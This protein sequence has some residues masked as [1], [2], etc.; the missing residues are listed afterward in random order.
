MRDPDPLSP[1]MRVLH[2]VATATRRGGEMFAADLVG[3]LAERGIE[4]RVSILRRGP[5]L[6]DFDSPV[7]DVGSRW[8]LPGLRVDAAALHRLRSIVRSWSPSVIQA[9]GGEAFKHALAV[10]GKVPVVYRRLGA[11]PRWLRSGARRAAYRGM[12]RRAAVIVAVAEVVRDETIELYDLDP[13]H[14]VMIPNGID[15][16]RLRPDAGRESVR[17]SLGLEPRHEVMLSVGALSWEKEPQGLLSVMASVCRARPDAVW[18][19][20]GDGPLREALSSS[21]DAVALGS[22]IRFLGARRDMGNLYA[23]GD[24]FVFGSRPDGM[25]GMPACLIEAGAA[26]LP[27]VAYDVAGVSELV[28]RWTAGVLVPAGDRDALEASVTRVLSESDR[29]AQEAARFRERCR[30]RFDISGVADRYLSV[31]QQVIGEAVGG[32]ASQTTAGV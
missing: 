21:A 23:A 29:W 9:H 22:R 15:L 5:H 26:G 11:A 30:H 18:L 1:E 31:Y 17:R 14:V 19:F 7:D 16:E 20:A 13:S 25:E 10:A 12:A 8:R 28:G 4:Q 32:P 27:T 24:V 6:I 3:A 2:V